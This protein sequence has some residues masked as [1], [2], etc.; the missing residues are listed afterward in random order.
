MYK[1][2]QNKYKMPLFYCEYSILDHARTDCMTYFGGMTAEDDARDLGGKIELLGR[3]STVGEATGCCV[4]R[5][6]DARA[7]NDWLYNW[8]PMATCVV[9][10]VLDDNQARKLILARHH[11]KPA[12]EVS[13]A[14]VGNTPSEGESLYWIKYKF[15]ADKRKDGFDA[16]AHLTEEEDSKDAGRNQVLGRWH[17]LGLGSGVAICLSKSE[18]DLFNWAYNWADMCNCEIKPVVH[19]DECRAV[20]QGKPDFAKKQQALIAKMSQ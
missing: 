10:P 13:Y 16:F 7:L 11:K 8:V 2:S 17:N 4:C 12:Y 19:D 1:R 18:E 9:W 6:P 5:A 15:H 20:I 14:S 3:W